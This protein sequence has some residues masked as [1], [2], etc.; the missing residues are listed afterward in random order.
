MEIGRKRLFGQSR[1][2]KVFCTIF[3]K[4]KKADS[5]FRAIEDSY[6]SAKLRCEKAKNRPTVLSEPCIKIFG[7]CLGVRV[8]QLDL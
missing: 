6:N 4:E 7:T 1:M 2:D 5:I 8:G 3:S